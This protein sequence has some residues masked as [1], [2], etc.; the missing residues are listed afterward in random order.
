MKSPA[1]RLRAAAFLVLVALAT[2]PLAQTPAP[3]G[4]T[5]DDLFNDSIVHDLRLVIHS[6]DWR[7][8]KETFQENTYY[9]C[10]FRWTFRGQEMVVRNIGIRSRGLGSRSPVKPGLRVDFDRYATDQQFL[11]LKSIVLDN[12]TQ[13]PSTIKERVTMKFFTRMGE[14]ASREAPARLFVNNEYIGLYVMVESVDKDFLKRVFG[15]RAPGDTEN[16]GYLFEY[17]WKDLYDFSYLG[18]DLT[19][20]SQLFSPQTHESATAEKLYRPIEQ[21]IKAINESTD[22]GFA[23][24]VSPYIDLNHVMK[25]LAIENF[26]AENDGVLGYAGMNNFYFYRFEETTRHR[27]LVWDKDNNF[28]E[29]SFPIKNR[30]D[31]NVLARRAME[32]ASYKTAYMTVLAAAA[33]SALEPLLDEN[34]LVVDTRGWLEREVQRQL[35]Q[36]RADVYADSK[37]PYTNERFEDE[38]AKVL[39]FARQRSGFVQ[40]AVQEETD[41]IPAWRR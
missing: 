28:W 1:A 23:Q 27:F 26:L 12:L 4:P 7:K 33:V 29:T 19:P 35:D 16:D 21:M 34:G 11:G 38:G 36:V 10:D 25:H 22:S 3:T 14:P 18:S 31:T 9:P 2:R 37:K 20:Y 8:L 5:T 6:A 13:D 40:A 32:I 30:V 41:S 39:D 24:A 15:E 17:K